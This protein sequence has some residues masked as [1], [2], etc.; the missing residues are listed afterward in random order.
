ND[1][2]VARKTQRSLAPVEDDWNDQVLLVV[3]VPGQHVDQ[4]LVLVRI[5]VGRKTLPVGILLQGKQEFAPLLGVA[6][7]RLVD[8]MMV[9]VQN[10]EPALQPPFRLRENGEIVQI[11]DLV[12]AVKLMQEEAQ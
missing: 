2:S 9:A 3:K 8:H 1:R 7:Q 12:M 5:G 10:V 11:L 6:L 4:P